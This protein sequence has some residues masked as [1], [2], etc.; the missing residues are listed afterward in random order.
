MQNAVF[1][2]SK[3]MSQVQRFWTGNALPLGLLKEIH[4]A[5]CPRRTPRMRP[6]ALF[7]PGLLTSEDVKS[8]SR[9]TLPWDLTTGSETCW[10]MHGKFR[11]L[12]SRVKVWEI[13]GIPALHTGMGLPPLSAWG[14]L[15][16][17]L[18]GAGGQSAFTR[19]QQQGCSFIL[20][21]T[22]TT[23]LA[24]AEEDERTPPD[25]ALGSATLPGHRPHTYP[26]VSDLTDV[27]PVA[28]AVMQHLQP[29][30]RRHHE[31]RE[32]SLPAPGVMDKT[33]GS[34]QGWPV[35]SSGGTDTGTEL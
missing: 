26:Q 1:L 21:G 29:E 16:G 2:T 11:L 28:L 5:K 8:G 32:R 9:H 19:P 33:E 15:M 13:L 3:D 30:G 35:Q 12:K 20:S 22:P 34:R 25:A 10:Q 24:A 4:L 31:A 27:A 17:L 6:G 23:I 7:P 14:G 18:Y